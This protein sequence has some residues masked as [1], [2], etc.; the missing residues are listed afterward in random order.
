VLD[1]CGDLA[2]LG[3]PLVGHVRVERGGHALHQQL[4][5]TILERPDTWVIDDPGRSPA[6]SFDLT[7]LAGAAR[8]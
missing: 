5:A 3:M 4:V 1:L 2:L 6:R 8:L 7:R